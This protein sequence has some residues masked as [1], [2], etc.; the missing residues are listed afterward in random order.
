[1]DNPSPVGGSFA[2][3]IWHVTSIIPTLGWDVVFSPYLDQFARHILNLMLTFS[4]M[5]G[6][7]IIETR[8]WDNMVE[9]G[10]ELGE[11]GRAKT[12]SLPNVLQISL[13]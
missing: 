4:L 11:V 10:S 13:S 5:C 9:V 7:L 8:L 2:F 1:M 6:I 3:Q 12:L